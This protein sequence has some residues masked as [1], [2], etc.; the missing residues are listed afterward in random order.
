MLLDFFPVLLVLFFLFLL[1]LFL[2]AIYFYF[3][4]NFRAGPTEIPQG[5]ADR[6]G[7]ADLTLP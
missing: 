1:L 4:F 7:I 5:Q 2:S 6:H 3:V